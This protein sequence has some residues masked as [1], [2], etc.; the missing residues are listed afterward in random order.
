MAYSS[1]PATALGFEDDASILPESPMRATA[2]PVSAGQLVRV[3]RS[4]PGASWAARTLHDERQPLIRAGGAGPGSTWRPCSSRLEPHIRGELLASLHADD[5]PGPGAHAPDARKTG[6]SAGRSLDAGT[7]KSRPGAGFGRAE[8]AL[9]GRPGAR[10]VP[11]PGQHGR[12]GGSLSEQSEAGRRTAPSFGFG[13][14][15]RF[16]RHQPQRIGKGFDAERIGYASPGPAAYQRPPEGE[17]PLEGS[18]RAGGVSQRR[19]RGAD[20]FGPQPLSGR[21]TG[22]ASAFPRSTREGASR[23]TSGRGKAE[24]GSNR[25]AADS[26]GPGQYGVRQR[27]RYL[28]GETQGGRFPGERRLRAPY[29]TCR[30]EGKALERARLGVESPGPASYSPR[31]G[32]E[33]ERRRRGAVSPRGG[34]GGAVG[35]TMGRSPRLG[36]TA[37]EKARA[38]VPGPGAYDD[39][40]AGAIGKAEARRFAMEEAEAEEA[41]GAEQRRAMGASWVQ[42]SASA[43]AARP[44]VE[45]PMGDPLVVMTGRGG[46]VPEGGG[47]SPP[48]G[49]PSTAAPARRRGANRRRS[50]RDS[51]STVFGAERVTDSS[52]TRGRRSPAWTFGTATRDHPV[53]LASEGDV[54]FITVE[55]AQASVR[56]SSARPAR[57]RA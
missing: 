18:P 5:T 55:E 17:P 46:G 33:D 45:R 31:T 7:W 50:P 37:A 44:L 40:V 49:R 12:L 10:G 34:G 24:R 32:A 16:H 38:A 21:R 4:G 54:R 36:L 23:V 25:D 29:E 39:F 14:A 30:F 35:S 3:S 11:G 20:G 52:P 57:R 28:D 9:G 43:R 15:A 47:R 48:S 2:R 56:P 41:E 13:R 51:Y 22:V 26:P 1:A 53:P 8:R 6:V 19:A 27:V 42:R